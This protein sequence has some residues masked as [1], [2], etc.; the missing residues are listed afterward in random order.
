MSTLRLL[1]AP[2]TPGAVERPPAAGWRSRLTGG[3]F[4]LFSSLR[5]VAYLPTFWA[6]AASADSS[7]HS[8]VTWG[9]W[10]GANLS[11]A[12]WLH[13]RGASV[14][15][16]VLVAASNAVM[17]ATAVTLIVALRL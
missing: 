4:A 2:S 5:V 17:C 1:Y 7:Q 14:R 6:I 10:L 3:A 15:G 13:E 11:T 8:L 9:I 12:L 16:A